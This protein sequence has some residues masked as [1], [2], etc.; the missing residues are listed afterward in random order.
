LDDDV[1]LN[2]AIVLPLRRYPASNQAEFDSRFA[3]KVGAVMEW[4]HTILDEA[5]NVECD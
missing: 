4:V 3:S 1:D 5:M 2:E